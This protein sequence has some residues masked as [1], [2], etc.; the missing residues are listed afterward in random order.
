M[1][2]A[3]TSPRTS[4]LGGVPT[5]LDDPVAAAPR[6]LALGLADPDAP[7][8]PRRT[9]VLPD[10]V[11]TRGWLSPAEQRDLVAQ[12]R[13]WAAPPAGLR[14]PRVPQGHLMTRAVGVPRVALAAL[15]L[16][17]HRR[18]HRRRAGEAAAA[19]ARRPRSACRRRVVRRRSPV[20]HRVRARRRDREPVRAG[21]APRSAPGRR[22]AVRRTRRHH[23]PRRRLRVPHGR[24]RPPDVAV[25]RRRAALR[26]SARVRRR[27]PSHLPRRP[28]GVPGHRARTGSACRP[29]ASASRCAR[30]G[31]RPRSDSRRSGDRAGVAADGGPARCRRGS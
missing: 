28:E 24:R 9:E 12:F 21:S 31:S 3:R 23:Q 13:E 1:G 18:R 26:R 5:T 25:H 4:A 22:G 8:G 30:R 27:E 19:R 2:S 29:A 20:Q 14:H 6:Q 10:V 7:A 15:R 11:L 16:L 17:P